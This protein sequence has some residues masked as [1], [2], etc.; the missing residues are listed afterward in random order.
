MDVQLV[1]PEPKEQGAWL[2]RSEDRGGQG[3]HMAIF[4]SDESLGV[5]TWEGT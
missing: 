3:P 4:L 2:A 1:W 5:S